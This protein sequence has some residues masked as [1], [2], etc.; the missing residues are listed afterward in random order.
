MKNM[1][2]KKYIAIIDSGWHKRGEQFEII[3]HRLS[4]TIIEKFQTN[5]DELWYSQCP[6]KDECP[7]SQT[8][9]QYDFVLRHKYNQVTTYSRMGDVKFLDYTEEYCDE[10]KND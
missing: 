8:T 1:I 4:R 5:E 7:S 10:L 3:D 2:G 6:E 9:Y